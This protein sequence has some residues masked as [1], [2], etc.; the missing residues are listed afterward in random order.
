MVGQDRKRC[1][2]RRSTLEG[3]PDKYAFIDAMREK[4][5]PGMNPK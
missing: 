4:V 5:I 3:K 2:A 1:L